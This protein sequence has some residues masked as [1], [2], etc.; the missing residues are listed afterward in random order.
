LVIKS[1]DIDDDGKY[2]CRA[3]NSEG[4]GHDSIPIYIETKGLILVFIDK[5]EY[6]S[7]KNKF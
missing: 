7:E 3:Q 1:V 4:F 6:F 2:F 5:F